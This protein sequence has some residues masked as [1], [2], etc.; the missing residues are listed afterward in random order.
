[1]SLFQVHL[2]I[3]LGPPVVFIARAFT[4]SIWTL[5]GFRHEKSSSLRQL[6]LAVD[7]QGPLHWLTIGD[8]SK[9]D[10]LHHQ[11][12]R[13]VHGH[14]GAR[15]FVQPPFDYGTPVQVDKQLPFR[16]AQ[17]LSEN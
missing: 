8:T 14:V 3:L 16:L 10:D 15:N 4:N 17:R 13:V 9:N 2:L 5:L 7:Q 12:G 11:M 6:C 1:M